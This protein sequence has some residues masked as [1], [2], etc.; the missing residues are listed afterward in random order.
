[1]DVMRVFDYVR[2]ASAADFD[3]WYDPFRKVWWLQDRKNFAATQAFHK[4]LL[5]GMGLERFAFTYLQREYGNSASW[6]DFR[7]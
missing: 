5:I 7:G 3:L 2:C 4:A 6:Q 1:M